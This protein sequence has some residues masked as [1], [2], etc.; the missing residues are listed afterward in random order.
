MTCF[1]HECR[2]IPQDTFHI[3]LRI[4]NSF[5]LFH[6]KNLYKRRY[7]QSETILTGAHLKAAFG[8]TPGLLRGRF[9][10]RVLNEIAYIWESKQ[11]AQDSDEDRLILGPCFA[12]HILKIDNP[13]Q[14]VA[15]FKME[16]LDQKEKL[17]PMYLSE[18]QQKKLLTTNMI[19]LIMVK[20]SHYAVYML[21]RYTNKVHVIDPVEVPR[22][23]IDEENNLDYSS[24]NDV[25]A[26]K[27]MDFFEGRKNKRLKES[28]LY[29]NHKLKVV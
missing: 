17:I 26:N 16:L 1:T 21:D 20:N 10:K 25:E 27:F 22:Q 13:N 3:P 24:L 2:I 18:K 15:N 7:G 8:P 14:G 23:E 29:H 19:F 6:N 28:N 5:F 4:N 11:P 9:E 12:E